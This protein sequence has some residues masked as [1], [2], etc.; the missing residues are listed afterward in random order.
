MIV[1]DAS[2]MVE[3]ITGNTTTQAALA[4][5]ALHAPHLIDSEVTSTLRR[6]ASAGRI[7]TRDALRSLT[8]L[9]ELGLTRYP[10]FGLFERMWELRD[11]LT[12]YDATYVAVAEALDCPL[13]TADARI[14]GAPGVRCEVTVVPAR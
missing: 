1:V 6:Q 4:G 3:A 10:S 7:S 5:R 12:S 2:A 14:A 8:V 9:R 11:N 13:V